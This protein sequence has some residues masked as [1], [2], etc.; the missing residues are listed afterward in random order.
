LEPSLLF[1]DEVDCMFRERS[2]QDHEATSSFQ[3]EWMTQ[4]DGLLTRDSSRVLVIGTTNRPGVLD[5]AIRRRLAR[6]F[7]VGLPT[8]DQRVGVLGLVLAAEKLDESV[9]LDVVARMT[10]G[11]SGSDLKELCRA[12]AML[13]VRAHLEEHP[14][15]FAGPP[16]A[17][18]KDERTSTL[19][20]SPPG[21]TKGAPSIRCLAIEDFRHALELVPPSC[22]VQIEHHFHDA[23]AF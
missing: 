7:Y 21:T 19:A 5:P 9:D 14:T 18:A 17:S 8:H 3:S 23:P 1:V 20:S 6:Q 13:P 4:W 10:H 12:A 15:A 16:P 22:A 11:Y 2:K